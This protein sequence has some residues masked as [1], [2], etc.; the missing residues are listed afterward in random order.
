MHCWFSSCSYNRVC[1][2]NYCVI[3]V[4]SSGCVIFNYLITYISVNT[5]NKLTTII[6][7]LYS[8]MFRITWAIF[9]LELNL[10]AMSLHSFWDPRC[11]HVF[12]IDVIY[13]II[14]VGCNNV[15]VMVLM[16]IIAHYSRWISSQ[17]VS[18]L[19][20]G[21]FFSFPC[22]Q[23]GVC[24]LA[25]CFCRF[26]PCVLVRNLATWVSSIVLIAGSTLLYVNIVKIN[27]MYYLH[28]FRCWGLLVL[29]VVVDGFCLDVA[30]TSGRCECLHTTGLCFGRLVTKTLSVLYGGFQLRFQILGWV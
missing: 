21:P 25:L 16:L 3:W 23:V 10:F 30:F 17:D 18:V 11:L 1:S 7:I 13:C 6:F 14:I 22:F 12:C 4:R 5:T 15:I 28:I 29:C 24:F 9:R 2:C 26:S 27:G 19:L 8:Y 20:V